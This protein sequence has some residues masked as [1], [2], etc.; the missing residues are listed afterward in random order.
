M[1]WRAK[2]EKS[3]S[4]SDRSNG[5]IPLRTFHFSHVFTLRT[6]FADFSRVVCGRLIA[7][8]FASLFH[9]SRP[10]FRILW[11]GRHSCEKSK[12]FV[13]YFF[14]ALIKREI[15]MKYKKCTANVSYFAVCFAKYL[16]NAKYEKCIVGLREWLCLGTRFDH[17]ERIS[18]RINMIFHI[19]AMFL[20]SVL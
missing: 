17:F 11:Q 20:L 2:R 13:V 12:D 4:W 18:Y 7:W 16:R 1:V 9:I 10:F 6:H 8:Y 19:F 3:V 14:A 15:R 5:N